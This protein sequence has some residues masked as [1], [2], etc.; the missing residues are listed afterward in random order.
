MQTLRSLKS[1]SHAAVLRNTLSVKVQPHLARLAGKQLQHAPKMRPQLSVMAAAAY[2][3]AAPQTAALQ[4]DGQRP[5]RVFTDF[6]VYKGKGAMQLKAIKPEWRSSANGDIS[7]TR[8]GVMLLEFAAVAQ[9]GGDQQ[10]YGQR[11]YDWSNKETFALRA[12]EMGNFIVSNNF[13]LVH[14][15]NKG[16]P[17]DGSVMK[18]LKVFPS[19]DGKGT[20]I[21]LQ[22]RTQGQGQG[23]DGNFYLM[24]PMTDGEMAVFKSIANYLI[25]KLL[26][27]DEIFANQEATSGGPPF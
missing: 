8:P 26:G 3:T 25:P 10:G 11:N 21:S 2:Q 24:V 17:G 9:G 5:S 23:Q 22:V 13:S 1:L 16:G 7:V 12:E 14:D 4:M 6:S 19:Q 20:M 18:T 27:F 15:P